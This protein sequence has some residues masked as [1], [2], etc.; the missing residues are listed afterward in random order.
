MK[1]LLLCYDLIIGLA[2]VCSPPTTLLSVVM[3]MQHRPETTFV[4]RMYA[5]TSVVVI[6]MVML[7]WWYKLP[8]PATWFT[9]S[10]G[11]MSLIP[12]YSFMYRDLLHGSLRDD[13]HIFPVLTFFFISFLLCVKGRHSL[14][15]PTDRPK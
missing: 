4:I 5:I 2:F 1:A 14:R 6:Y 12:L 9:L 8:A 15:P 10:V 11:M 7:R 13:G 3:D